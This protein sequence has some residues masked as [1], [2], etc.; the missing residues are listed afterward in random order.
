MSAFKKD[1]GDPNISYEVPDSTAIQEFV[2]EWSDAQERLQKTELPQ[3]QEKWRKFFDQVLMESVK[4]T[5]NEIK[6]KIFDTERSIQSIN[7]VLKLTNFE[8]LPNDQRYLKI[9][10]QSSTDERIRR[11]RRS[12]DELGKIL[13]VGVRTHV[14]TQSQNVMGILVPFVEEFQKEPSYRDYVTDVRNHFQFEVH[15]LRR[16]EGQEDERVEVF[17][18]ARKDA[19]SSAQTTQLA[20]A[21]L[22]SCL[23]YRFHFHDPVGGQETLRILVLDEFGG[24]FDNEKPREILKLLDKMGFQSILVSPMSKADLLAESISQLVFVHKVSA[25][26]SK[27]QSFEIASKADYTRLLASMVGKE[28]NTAVTGKSV[29][30]EA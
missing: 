18:G 9:D 3:A 13:G 20:Y 1:F 29:A 28:V 14:E 19:K 24:K 4:D 21:L 23:A 10:L 22:A 26:H 30:L 5:I 15:S 27:V 2:A 6:S 7:E 25:T 16:R 12:I 11:F 17:T 8:D